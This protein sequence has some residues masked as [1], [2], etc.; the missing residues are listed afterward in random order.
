MN[1][2]MKRFGMITFILV[3]AMVVMGCQA[4]PP[5]ESMDKDEDMHS[6]EMMDKDDEMKS[7][8]MMDKDDEMKSEDVM[9]KDDEMKSEEMMDK[10]DEMKSEEMMDKDD[11]MKSEEMMD[12][13]DEMKSEEM[14]DKDDDM[15]SEEMMNDGPMAPTFAL[16]DL[17][18]NTVDLAGLKGEKVYVKFWA[19]WCPICLSGLDEMDTL[20]GEMNDFKVITVV[21]P[22]YNGELKEDEF[23]EWF[24]TRGTENMT[25]LLDDGG[26]ITKQFGVRGYPTSV[27]IGS[28]GVLVQQFPGHVGAEQIKTFFSEE[29]K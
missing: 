3:M 1:K 18:G 25:V 19:S 21:A 4:T 7:E 24:K 9:D 17:D 16:M 5:Q 29:V 23:K 28:D 10:D 26:Q 8:E 15:M 2:K 22:G 12:K 6:E 13:D 27:F 20:A 14:M 11:E